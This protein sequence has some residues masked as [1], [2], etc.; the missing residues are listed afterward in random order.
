MV[1][2]AEK[3]KADKT[4]PMRV[5]ESVR[6]L[7]DRAAELSG[8]SRT[9]FILESATA[10]AIDVLLDQRLF[11][12]DDQQMAAVEAALANPPKPTAALKALLKSKAPWE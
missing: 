7:I 3:A 11:L 10:H 8:K 1:A 9:E 6:D 5:Q 4:I 12:V 2:L